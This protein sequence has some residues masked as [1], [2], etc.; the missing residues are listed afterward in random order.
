M[1]EPLG[2]YEYSQG[3]LRDDTSTPLLAIGAAFAELPNFNLLTENGSSRANLAKT[4]LAIDKNIT[5]ADVF[6]FTADVAFKYYGFAFEGEYDLRRIY[7]IQS[8]AAIN[9]ATRGQGLRLQ[10]GYLFL[11]PHFEV[12]FRYGIVDPN[13][14]KSGDRKQEFTPA[15]SYYIYKHRLKLTTDYSLLLQQNPSGGNFKD[16]RFRIQAQLYF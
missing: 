7:H 15:L 9:D 1:L 3:D 5:N 13:N 4:I 16:N 11:P 14:H 12:A 2:K 8:T 6:Q 10:A